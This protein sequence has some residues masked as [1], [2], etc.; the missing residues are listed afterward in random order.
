MMIEAQNCHN[1]VL[2]SNLYLE[3]GFFYT[4]FVIEHN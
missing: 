4:I 1:L 3:L 2:I